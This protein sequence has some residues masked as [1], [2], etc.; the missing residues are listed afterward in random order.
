MVKIKMQMLT[1]RE[2]DILIANLSKLSEEEREIAVMISEGFSNKAIAEIFK[3]NKNT[4]NYK[5]GRIFNVLGANTY[6]YL[7]PRIVVT[8]AIWEEEQ[9][10]ERRCPT[11]N[12]K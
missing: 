4:L 6:N 3:V 7:I 2:L 9:K 1:R 8:R 11:K 12:G 5:I 10:T